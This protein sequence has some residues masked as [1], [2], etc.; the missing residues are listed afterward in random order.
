[1]SPDAPGG[2][3]GT[4]PRAAPGR[5]G[6]G[7]HGQARDGRRFPGRRLPGMTPETEVYRR[8]EDRAARQLRKTQLPLIVGKAVDT[9]EVR[10]REAFASLD[11][12]G[13][14]RAAEAVRAHTLA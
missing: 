12:D 14:R 13:L 9:R 5:P 1:G 8:F 2:P 3:A 7:R 6:A 4:G 10:R 11:G